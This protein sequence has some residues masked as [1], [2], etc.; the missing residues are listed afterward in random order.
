MW[1]VYKHVID[2]KVPF[3]FGETEMLVRPD[4]QVFYT[5]ED[6]ESN[7]Q[8]MTADPK[9]GN[10]PFQT[11]D[12]KWAINQCARLI[13]RDGQIVPSTANTRVFDEETIKGI[14]SLA[15]DYAGVL[16][17]DGEINYD[18]CHDLAYDIAR[19]LEGHREV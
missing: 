1:K 12:F 8:K 2:C 10:T 15:E 16:C 5:V 9:T 13:A 14:A 19:Y 7:P 11:D 4:P 3:V 17:H 6:R 18:E